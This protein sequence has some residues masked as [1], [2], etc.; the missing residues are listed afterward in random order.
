MRPHLYNSHQQYPSELSS[1]PSSVQNYY[2][3]AGF[4]CTIS[5]FCHDLKTLDHWTTISGMK[6]HKSKCWIVHLGWSNTRHKY[7]LGKRWLKVSVTEKDLRVLV[8]AKL[9]MNQQCALAAKRSDQNQYNQPVKRGHHPDK[10]TISALSV[11]CA[12]LG[13]RV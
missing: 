5:Q 10:F 9:N 4:A 6:F 13:P 3:D 1:R 8:G 12:V 2:S 7:K 11:L